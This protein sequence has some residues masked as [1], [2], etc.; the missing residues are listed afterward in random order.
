VF[1]ASSKL[2]VVSEIMPAT[3]DLWYLVFA[4]W[5]CVVG[6]AAVQGLSNG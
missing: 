5:G 4:F 3:V 1:C 2:C 6:W